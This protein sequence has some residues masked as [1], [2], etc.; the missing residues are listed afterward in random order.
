MV[1]L[2]NF[3]DRSKR[4]AVIKT[5]TCIW[6]LLISRKTLMQSCSLASRTCWV[7]LG[8]LKSFPCSWLSSTKEQTEKQMLALA[9][10]CI[11]SP[12]SGVKQTYILGSI[13]F[14]WF[15]AAFV[16]K[17]VDDIPVGVIESLVVGCSKQDRVTMQ[18]LRKSFYTDDCFSG[19]FQIKLT[20]DWLYSNK[21]Q[22]LA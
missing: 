6:L 4:D 5:A 18:L 17:G 19:P 22:I 11:F 20:N 10:V 16:K 8:T 12:S 15:Y 9:C 13:L 2:F 7:G 3:C 14:M 21:R 1:V